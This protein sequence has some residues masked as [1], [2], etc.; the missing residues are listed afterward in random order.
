MSGLTIHKF[1]VV[2][3]RFMLTIPRD[4][5]ILDVQMQFGAPQ[6]WVL[7]DGQELK[8]SRHFIVMG[9]GHRIDD[10][11]YSRMKYIG[12]FQME[13]GQMVWHLFEVLP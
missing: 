1:P 11:Q 2:P 9:T 13:D 7:L 10:G 3:Y 5:V 6:M 8:I 4:A 12:T